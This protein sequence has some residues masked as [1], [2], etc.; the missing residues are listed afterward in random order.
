MGL[1]LRRYEKGINSGIEVG[2]PHSHGLEQQ[3]GTQSYVRVV[4]LRY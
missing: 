2:R 4:G 1:K 3:T